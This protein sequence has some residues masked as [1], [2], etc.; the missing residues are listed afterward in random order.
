MT[1]LTYALFLSFAVVAIKKAFVKVRSLDAAEIGAKIKNIRKR[2]K[3]KDGVAEI[4]TRAATSIELRE[5]PAFAQSDEDK[6][7]QEE[8]AS[9]NSNNPTHSGKQGATTQQTASM[10]MV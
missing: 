9:S 4:E 2:G 7:A 10:T 5:R 8:A 6:A 3:K 1:F